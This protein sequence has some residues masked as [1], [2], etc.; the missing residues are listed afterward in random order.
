MAV[1]TLKKSAILDDLYQTEGKA[2]LVNGELVVM[3]PTGDDP[4][5]AGNE[6]FVS[7]RSYA[8][9]AGLGRAVGDN[10]GFVVNL[11]Q[12]KSFSPDAAFFVGQRTGMRFL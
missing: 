12:R 6:V 2:E 10:K 3:A 7:L 5:F 9:E 4:G 1:N 11:P 8:R